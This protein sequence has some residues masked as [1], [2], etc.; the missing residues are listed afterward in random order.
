[1]LI[2]I[3]I[4]Y[5]YFIKLIKPIN[6]TSFIKLYFIVVFHN[7][8]VMVCIANKSKFQK[9][10][11]VLNHYNVKTEILMYKTHSRMVQF[12][13]FAIMKQKCK[14]KSL[15]ELQI[16]ILRGV[17]VKKLVISYKQ[18]NYIY[19]IRLGTSSSRNVFTLPSQNLLGQ[20]L[21][22]FR[23]GTSKGNL[24]NVNELIYLRSIS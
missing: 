22:F 13:F 19:L 1:M 15:L 20:F 5:W 23:F 4:N 24:S 17:I 11:C 8:F 14:Y 12:N 16:Q 21:Y 2:V 10:H 7:T 6:H 18:I 9:L 3:N